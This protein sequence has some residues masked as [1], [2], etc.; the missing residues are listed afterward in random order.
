MA[1]KP[2]ALLL[3][4]LCVLFCALVQQTEAQ[5]FTDVTATW[6]VGDSGSGIGSAWGD[7]DADGDLDLY[8][9]FSGG[10]TN[11]LYTNTG[12]A[13][14]ASGQAAQTGSNDNGAVWGDYDGDGDLDLFTTDA[15]GSD[16]L[17]QNSGGSFS[18]VAATAGVQTGGDYSPGWVDYDRDGDLDLYIAVYGAANLLFQ[19]DGTGSFSD[20]ASTAGVASAGNTEG[21]AWG[22]YNN[23]G[24]PDLYIADNSAANVLYE[25]AGDGTF[26]D[27]TSTATVGAGSNA[28]GPAWGDY[29][30]DG[31]LDLHVTYNSG[32][33]DALYK[34]NGDGTF[35]D[36]ASGAGVNQANS[37]IASGWADFDFDGDLDVYVNVSGAANLLYSNN[38]NG[39]FTDV[40][41]TAS[42][43][44][45]GVGRGT[46]WGDVDSDGDLDLFINNNGSKNKLFQNSS[47]NGKSWLKVKLTGDGNNTSAIGALV[48]AWTGGNSQRLQVEGISSWNSQSSPERIFGFGNA[49]TVDS[50]IV[51]WPSG[52]VSASFTPAVSATLSL[53]EPALTVF[54]SAATTAGVNDASNSRSAAWADYDA[55][56][57]LDL[58]VGNQS[59]AN[60]LYKNSGSST[61][62]DDA[63]TAGVDDAGTAYGVAWADYDGDGLLDLALA[64]NAG[65][66]RL[67]SNAGD[68]TFTEDATAAGVDFNGGS[69]GL[70]WGDYDNDGWVDLYLSVNG[71]A[72]KLYSNA[73]DGTFTEIGAAAGVDDAGTGQAAMWGDYDG[74]GALDLALANNGGTTRLYNNNGNGTFTE[75]ASAAG[76]A[77]GSTVRGLSWADFI[78]DLYIPDFSGG[79]DALYENAGNGTFTDVA[80]GYGLKDDTAHR[81]VAWGDY[82]NDGRLDL[83]VTGTARNKLHLAR[84][85]GPFSEVTAAAGI[86]DHNDSHAAVFGDYDGDGDLDLFVANNGLNQFYSNGG[87]SNNWL[88]VELEGTSS[89]S[90]GIGALVIAEENGNKLYREIGGSSGYF[91]QSAQWAHFGF[92]TASG[93]IDKVTVVWTSGFSNVLTSIS[94]DQ[95]LLLTERSVVSQTPAAGTRNAARTSNVSATF[96][97]PVT[98][99]DLNNFIVHGSQSGELG[100]AYSGEGTDN[101]SF[102]PTNDFLPGEEI[103]VRFADGTSAGLLTVKGT[104]VKGY[105]YRL[106]AAAGTGPAEFTSA[107]SSPFSSST[108]GV[109]LGDVDGDG[110]LDLVAA[111][112]AKQNAVYLNDGTGAMVGGPNN[113]GTGSDN[114][115]S[116]DLGDLDGDGDLDI[117][118]GNINE[119]NTSHLND[120]SGGFASSANFGT[121]SDATRPVVLGDL[122]G[123][124]YMDV[125]VGNDGAQN[126]VYYND[127]AGALNSWTSNFGTGT[128]ATK[129]LEIG[130]VDQDGD[131]DLWLG[132]NSEANKI[133]LNGGWGSF[134]AGNTFG[135]GSDPSHWL[136][137]GDVDGD[138]DMDVVSANIGSQARPEINDGAGTFSAGTAFGTAATARGLKLGDVD[139]DGDLDAA[140]SYDSGTASSVFLNNA[141]GVFS[142]GTKTFAGSGSVTMQVALGDIDGDL[143]LDI[144]AGNNGTNSEVH[145]NSNAPVVNSISPTAAFAS[146]PSTG[147]VTATF[148]VAVTAGDAASFVVHSSMRGK[149]A[150]AYSGNNSTTLTFNPTNNFFPGETV[151]ST[152]VSTIQDGS[153]GSLSKGY[154]W[155]FT[156]QAAVGPGQFTSVFSNYGSSS[157]ADSKALAVGDID[158]DGDIDAVIAH[159]NGQQNTAYLNN[160]TGS[161]TASVQNYGTGADNSEAIAL[162]DM[163]GD[164]DVDVALGNTSQQNIAYLNNG[165]GS[166]SAGSTNFG[167]GSDATKAVALGDVDG[168][169]DLDLG[170]GNDGAQNAVYL[171]NGS[172][173]LSAGTTNFGTGSDA[174]FSLVFGDIDNDGD[175]DLLV[176]NNVQQ[177]VAYLNDGS[178]GLGTSQNFGTGS[179]K[180]TSIALGDIDGD[181]DLDVAVG[182]NTNTSSQNAAH[183]NNGSGVFS[184]SQNFGT[185]TDWTEAVALSDVDGD[186]DLDVI[187]ANYGGQ[188]AAYL[189]NGSGSFSAGTRNLG[190]ATGNT[191][192][193]V[194]GDV[195]GDGDIDIF[196]TVNNANDVLYFN[197]VAPTVSSISPTASF[198][199][200]PSTGNVTATFSIAVTAGDAASFVVH[201]SMRG[202]KA[203]AYSG[204]N[205]TTLTF[206]PTND[207]YPG[208]TVFST[209]VSTIND[210]SGNSLNKGYVWG[211]TVETAVGPGSFTSVFSNFGTGSDVTAGVDAGD[212]DGD[213]DLDIAQVNQGG[214]GLVQLNNGTGTFSGNFRY[215]GGATDPKRKV[216]LVDVDGDGD[217]DVATAHRPGQ[218]VAYL[219]DGS[220]NFTSSNNIGPGGDDTYSIH[221]ADLNGDGALDVAAGNHN[222]Q[223]TVHLNNGSGVLNGSSINFG[224]GSDATYVVRLADVDNDGDVDVAVGNNAQQDVLYFNDGSAGFGT[225]SNF[226]TG[227][228]AT[229]WI[230]LADVDGDGDTD[231]AVGS[232]GGQD[233]AYLNDGL[234]NFNAGTK[235]FGTGSDNTEYL[236]FGDGDGDGDVDIATGHWSQQDVVYVNDGSGNFS[237]GSNFGT[238]SDNTW[239][240]DFADIDGDGD[241]DLGSGV[242]GQNV[243][244]L[245]AIAPTVSSLSPTAS[246]ASAPSTG[247]VTATFSMAVTGGDAASFV[248]HSSMR[249]KKAGAYSGNNS[250]T[251]TFNPT[252]NFFPGETVFS[253]LTTTVQNTAGGK[254]AKG[255]VWGFRVQAAV[256]SAVFS[257]AASVDAA[258]VY[259]T[260]YTVLG[261]LDGDGDL[262]LVAGNMDQVNR[263]YLAN[264][265]GTFASG[266]DIDTPTNTNK[267]GALG[268]LD[269]DG[270]LDFVSGSSG[271]ANRVYLSNGN[272]TFATGND[273][274][275]PANAT[276]SV[277]LGDLDGD[278]DLDLVTGNQN[279]VNRVYLSN[280]NGTFATGNDVDTPTD[281]TIFTAL[282]DLDGDGDLDLVVAN[283][284]TNKLHLGNGDGT[285]SASSNVDTPTDNTRKIDLGDL[286]SDGDLDL[287]TVNSGAVNR[288]YLSNGNGTFAA[289]SQIDASVNTT[290]GLALGDVDGDGDLDLVAGNNGEANRAYLSN[291]NGTFASGSDVDAATNASWSI[292]LGDLDGDGDLDMIEG[293]QDLANRIQLNGGTSV[294][295]VSSTSPA[296]AFSNAPSSGNVT[297]TFSAAVTGGD[298]ASFRV[299]GSMSGKVS[300]AYSGNNSTTLT[301]NPTNNFFAGETVFST[302]V[303][304]IRNSSNGSLSSGYAWSFTAEST[305]APGNFSAVFS[306][307]VSANVQGKALALGDVD[308]DGDL[309]LALGKINEQSVL[310]DNDGSGSFT[311]ATQNIGGASDHTN[312]MS[313]GDVDG[314]GD[315][316]LALGN[317]NGFG[318]DEVYFNDGSGGFSLNGTVGPSANDTWAVELADMDGD[319]FLDVVMGNH[320]QQN[321]V[322]LNDKTGN[323]AASGLNFGNSDEATFHLGIGDIDNDGDLDAVMG[324]TDLSS[325]A[326]LQ[327]KAFFNDGTGSLG[328]SSNFGTGSDNSRG[329]A[330]GD[331]DGDGDLDVAVGNVS[332]EQNAVYLNNG[333][334]TFSAGTRNFGSADATHGVAF[335][336][337]DGDGDLDIAAANAAQQNKVFLNDGAGNFGSTVDYGGASDNSRSVAMGDVDGDGD[338]DLLGGNQSATS[339]V[340][341]NATASS[342]PTVSSTSPTASFASAPSTGNVTATFS[343]AVT[344]GDAASFVVHSSMRG[345]KAGAFSGNNSTTLTFNPT[346]N[347]FPGETVFS[348]L[349]TTV[350]NSSGTKLAKG[351]VWGFTVEAAVGP[352]VFNNSTS[353][354]DTPTN[355]TRSVSLGDVDGDGD[356]DLLAGN[357]AQVNRVYLSNG[358]GSFASGSDVDTPTNGT[359][360]VTL[361]DLDG[362]GDLDL[363]T[364]NNA[365]VNRVYL[366]NGNGTFASG[367]DVDAPTNNTHSMSL[368]DLDGDG[369]LDLVTG[370][371]AQV[372][373]VYLSNGNGTFAS[374]GDVDTPTNNTL[375][376]SLGDL[377][378]DGDLDLVAGNGQAGQ[379]NRVY[380][381]NGNGTFASGSDVDTPTNDTENVSLGDL[382]GDGDLD[383]V[384]GNYGQVNRLYLGNG[385]GTFA[386]GSDVDTPTNNTRSAL[387][388]DVDGDGDLD[389]ITGND[390]ANR[391]YL[392]NGNGTFA[393]GSDVDTPT[394]ATHSITLGDMDGDGDLDIVTGNEAQVNR[395]YL[396]A[397]A[398]TAPTVSSTSPTASF[399]S[400]PS[401]GNVTATFS[402]AVTGGDA[403]SFRVFG[404][405]SGKVSGAYSGNNSTTLTFNP[406]NNF[407]PGE[408]V[409]STLVSTIRDGSGNSLSKGYSW[410]FVAAANSGPTNFTAVFSSVSSAGMPAWSAVLGDVDADGDLDAGLSSLGGQNVVELN[411]GQGNFTA[412]NRTFGTGTD[413][414][415]MMALADIDGDGDLD[416]A[417]GNKS[418]EQNAAYLNDGS[419]N[420]NAGTRNFGTGSDETWV[421]V[422]GDVDSDGDVD[423]AVGNYGTQNVVYFNDGAGNFSAGSSNFGSGSEQTQ[424]MLFGDID[425]DGDLDLAV[426]NYAQQNV[427]YKN[428]GNGSF[429]AG[430]VNFG[431]ASDNTQGLA[432]GDIDGDGDLDVAAGNYLQQNAAYLNDGAGN[433]TAGTKNFGTGS[434]ATISGVDFA[435]VDVDSDLDVVV[436]NAGGQNVIYLNDASGNFSAGTR[437]FGTG[438]DN[439]VSVAVGDVDGDGDLDLLAGVSAGASSVHF[440]AAAPFEEVVSTVGV[441]GTGNEMGAAVGDFDGDGDQDIFV[442]AS[443][444]ANLLY[445]NNGSGSFTEV[446]SAKGV[447]DAGDDRG[448]SFGDYDADGDLDL[449]VTRVGAGNFLYKNNGSGSFTDDAAT[450]GVVDGTTNGQG[451]SWIDYDLDGDL[452]L[453]LANTSATASRLFQNNGA[454]VFTDV[455][456]SVGVANAG[457][458]QQGAWADYDADGDPDL[459][460]TDGASGGANSLYRNDSGGSSFQDV[461]ATAGVNNTGISG[462]VVWVDYDNDGDFDIFTVVQSAA[463]KLYRNDGSG[464]FVDVASTVGVDDTGGGYSTSVGDFDND[465]DE[466]FVVSRVTSATNLFYINSGT[467]TFT[468]NAANMGVTGSGAGRG[469][470][471]GDFD[472]DGDLDLFVSMYGGANQY[473]RNKGNN[474][475]WLHVKLAGNGSTTNKN[476]I[477]VEVK[478]EVGSTVQR[479]VVDGGSGGYSQP[480]LPV[481]FGLGGA[482]TVDK[483]I[484]TWAD[485]STTVQTNVS[486]N[487]TLTINE[488][489]GPQVSSV[490]PTAAF[491]SAPSTGN[492]TATFS[493]AVTAADAAS[494]VVHSSMRGKRAGAYSGNNS[495]T[496]TFN[497][498]NNFFPGETVF[499]TLTTTVQNSSG[500]RLSKG[501]VWSFNVGA[502]VAPTAFNN[503]THDVATATNT[504][505]TVSLGDLDGDGDLDLLAGNNGEANLVYLGNLDGTFSSGSSVSTASNATFSM[506]L[507]DLDGDGDLDLLEGNDNQTNQLY[508]GN[509]NGTFAGGSNVDATSNKTYA[510]VLGDLDG[511][512]D[513]DLVAGNY[514]SQ[515]NRVYLS[516]GNGT[517]ATGNDVDATT[518][519][520]TSVDVGDLDGDGDLDLLVGDYNQVNS[521]YLGNGDGTFASGNQVDG[522]VF[523]TWSIDLG[524]LD[525][526]GDLDLV[527]GGA[528]T[529]VNRVYLSN[530]NGTFANGNNVDSPTNSTRLI[531]L[532]DVDGDGD[533]DLVAANEGQANR[534]YLSNGNGTFVAGSDLATPT[535][536]TWAV[537]LGDL[538]GDGDLDLVAGNIGQVN[539]VYLNAEAVLAETQ[540]ASGPGG[541]HVA[542][543]SAT[544]Q[545][546][547]IGV[548]GDGSTSVSSL[549][550]TLSDLSTAT[551]MVAA[552]LSA[553]C[554]YSSTDAV[555]DQG[556]A[557]LV[558][559]TAVNIGSATTLSFTADTVPNA[560]QRYY[561]AVAKIAAS[562]T[563]GHAFRTSFAAGGLQTSAGTIGTAVAASDNDRVTVGIVAS[564]LV[565]TTQPSGSTSGSALTTQPVLQAQDANGN[566][567]SD[568]SGT[569][570]LTTTAAGTLSNATATLSAGV[571]TFSGLSYAAT[572]DGESVALTAASSGLSSAT[573]T[574][575]VADVIATKLVFTT[576]PAGA[577]HA[578]ALTTQ[579]VVQAQDASG[580]LDTGMSGTVTLAAS[581]GALSN[582]TA[583]MSAGVATFSGL[584][585]SGISSAVTLTAAFSSSGVSAA[586][587]NGLAVVIAPLS[588]GFSNQSVVYDGQ[589]KVIGISSTP[590]GVSYSVTYDGSATAPTN[591]GTYTVVATATDGNYTGTATTQFTITGPAAPTTTLSASLTT[592]PIPLTVQFA[593]VSTGDYS[594]STL[595]TG[596][597]DALGGFTSGSVT[598]TEPGTYTAELTVSGPG[599]S[600]KSSQTIVVLGP[601]TIAAI[602]AGTAKEDEVLTL[603]L[604]GKD[605]GSGT[606]SVSGL[607]AA[608]I[609]SH[610]IGGD[611]LTFTPVKDKAGSTTVTVTRTASTGLSTLQAVILT[612]TPVDDPPKIVNL[613]STSSGP[614]DTAITVGGA[615]H[616]V[617]IDSD[618]SKFEWSASGYK[619]ELVAAAAGGNGGVVF[620]PLKDKFGQTTAKLTLKD[621][622]TG[623]EVAQDVTLTWMPVNDPP[624]PPAIAKPLDKAIDI[625]LATVLSWSALDV[626]M[627]P[628]KFDVFLGVVGQPQVKVADKQT[629]TTYSAVGLEPGTDYTWRIVARDPSEL[630]AETTASFKTEADKTPPNISKLSATA[631]NDGMRIVWETDEKAE[632]ILNY[633]S[634]PTDPALVPEVGEI[635]N[636]TAA[637][638]KM[639]E[640]ALAQLQPATWYDFSV[641]VRDRFNNE[642]PATTSRFRTLAAPDIIAPVITPG[643]IQVNGITEEGG[644]VRW[645]TDE[646]SIGSVAYFRVNTPAAKLAQAVDGTES[647]EL[648]ELTLSRD[649]ALQLT[650]LRTASRYR[651]VITATD[652]SNNSSVAVEQHFTTAAKADLVAPHFT[653]GPGARPQLVT[654]EIE[655]KAD[656]VVLVEVR[657]D[658]DMTPAD[659]SVVFGGDPAESHQVTLNGLLPG[660]TYSYQVEV[661]DVGTNTTTS[662]ILTFET[663]AVADLTAA[664]AE[665]WQVVPS[666]ESALLDFGFDELVTARVLWWP[667]ADPTAVF[668]ADIGSAALQHKLTLG[669]LIAATDYAY[670]IVATDEG[671][672]IS[673]PIGGVF[674]TEAEP[675]ILNPVIVS[676]LIDAKTLEGTVLLVDVNELVTLQG[677]LTLTG[678][679]QDVTVTGAAVGDSKTIGSALKKNHS[680]AL[681]QLVPGGDYRVD[682]VVTDPYTNASSGLL[683]FK[684]PLR[685]DTEAPKLKQLPSILSVSD[686][687]VRLGVGYNENVQLKVRYFPTADATTAETRNFTKRQPQHEVELN[688]LQSG[689]DYTAEL[690]ARDA[691]KLVNTQSISFTT[692]LEPDIISPVFTQL[693]YVEDAQLTSVRLKFEADEPVVAQLTLTPVDTA[694]GTIIQEFSANAIEKS[695]A[696]SLEVSGLSPGVR[697]QYNLTIKDAKLNET[698]VQDVVST[699]NE[700]VLPRIVE[701][702]TK[703]KIADDRAWI[704]LK[705][706]IPTRVEVDYALESSP[707]NIQSEKPKGRGK[708][709]V[710]QLTNL[711]P[712]TSYIYTTRAVDDKSKSAS[713]PVSGT[714]RTAKGPDL[715]PPQIQGPP[716]VTAIF[717]SRA[718]IVWQ[719]DEPSDTKV[720]GTGPEGVKVSATNPAQTLVHEI[721]LTN[722]QPASTYTYRVSSTDLATNT[723]TSAN[724]SFTT[725]AVPDILPPVF[726]QNPIFRS[727][728]HNNVVIAYTANEPSTSTVEVGTT[729]NYELPKSTIGTA[730][731]DH[732]IQ[733]NGLAAGTE[734]HFRVGIS[735]ALGNGPTF[736]PNFVVT[737]DAAPD[738][739]APVI[740][741]GPLAVT[742]TESKAIIEW[743]T[744]EPADRHVRFWKKDSPNEGGEVEQGERVLAHQVVLNNLEPGTV[745]EYAASSTDKEANGPTTS[746]VNEFRTKDSPQLPAITSGPF[747]E[748]DESSATITWTTNVPS[749]SIVDLGADTQYGAHQE[750]KDLVLD[751][752]VVFENLD[753]AVTYHYKVTSIDLSNNTV[754]TDK[755]GGQSYS[756]D[757][758]VRTLGQ[759][760]GQPPKLIA[761]PVA[762]W[763]NTTV[764]ISWETDE[765][766]TSRIEWLNLRTGATG[767]VDDNQRV[768]QHNSTLTGLKPRTLYA[769]AVVSEDA[770]GNK[771]TWQPSAAAKAAAKM[772]Y[773]RGLRNLASGKVAQPP[774]GAGTFVTDSFPDTRLPV[775]TAGP[776]VR[777]K[778][779]ESVTIEWQTDELADSFVRFGQQENTLQE[780]VGAG[781]DVQ[782]HS[783][784]LTNLTPS[785]SYFFKVESTDPSGNG[786]T[787]SGIAVATTAA[788]IDLSPPRYVREPKVVATTDRQ[789]TLEWLG[790]EAA[791]ATIEYRSQNSEVLVRQVRER[792]TE[793][794][795]TLTNLTP[796][797][798][799]QALILLRDAN[800]NQTEQPFELRFTTDGEPDLVPPR[801]LTEPRIKV[802]G[803]RSVIIVWETDELSDSFVDFDTSPYLGQVVGN[804]T[805]TTQHEIRLTNLEPDSTYF[806]RAGSTDRAKNGPIESPVSS[807]TTLSQPDTEPPAVPSAVQA[808][809]GPEAV[810]L[811][812]DAV[813]ASDLGGYTVYREDL[814]RRFV[815]VATGLTQASYLDVGLTNR[816]TYRYRVSASD[817]QTPA[818]ES[819]SSTIITARPSA[820]ALGE[821]PQIVGL[822]QGAEAGKPVVLIGNAVPLDVAA[823]LSYT[824]QVSTQEDFSTM[825]DR[826]G[827]I[828]E[829]PSGTTRWRLTRALDPQASYWFRTRIFD[830]RFEGPWSTPQLLRPADA[831]TATNSED[832][833]GDGTVGFRDFF[834]MS[835][836]FGST[837]AVLD[838]DQGGSVDGEDFDRFKERFGEVMPAKRLETQRIAVAEGSRVEVEAEAISANRVVVRLKL[839]GVKDLSGY[840]FSL[841][842]DPPILRYMGRVD[843]ALFGGRGA[844]LELAHEGD[845]LAIGEHLRGRQ[846]ALDLSE[847]WEIALLFEMKGAPRNVE[848]RVEE[849]YLGTG[850]G[851]MLRVEQEGSAR[852]VPQVYALYANYP[853]PFNPSTSIPL[854]IPQWADG[855]RRE[856]VSLT[857]FN[858]LGQV[859]RTWDLSGWSPG[860]HSLNWDG[861]D[862]QGHAVASGV[863][864]MRLRAGEFVQVR[865]AL[866]LR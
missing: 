446:A 267:S 590:S 166:F 424:E 768:F 561:I 819:A 696:H 824:V 13:F 180:T 68:G 829:S 523:A 15:A 569:V 150:G 859:V 532:G 736:F 30:N 483:L 618:M 34:N 797:T 19:N 567:D 848:L 593:S 635:T 671:G 4:S 822:E 639:F 197:A 448:A 716:S 93:N 558:A 419:G 49:T 350:Q 324:N 254:L 531:K 568:F 564:K 552:D 255:H 626:D 390:T 817:A 632:F 57:D 857:L 65:T 614:E 359:H 29:N 530:G 309:D 411:D 651:L 773:D 437:N 333:S 645:S 583:T 764:V 144:V 423:V 542:A 831:L 127:G 393:S 676:A 472:S 142:A 862:G 503:V 221:F 468:E 237:A 521:V 837:D 787:E 550:L 769:I 743:S 511:D 200:A 394:N 621:P 252:N 494:F 302:L 553:L 397:L 732:E 263:V 98:A 364:G 117:V 742:T 441:N 546:F 790:D 825:V 770:A 762:K 305:V 48:E 443:N 847:G 722:L 315:L 358:N 316:D 805:Y 751:H 58:Y 562:A 157:G 292:S 575:F 465:G 781:Q 297:A 658:T 151:F 717:D 365:Q 700:I 131:L 120:G 624:A 734:Y 232:Y 253:T 758:T 512:G 164:G 152:L 6:G 268:D 92:G 815:A 674:T 723:T 8:V 665:G 728:S 328:T 311:A 368:G 609:A 222:A 661:V 173:S 206:N 840:G 191:S 809:A 782:Q 386:S 389:F 351:Y 691:A 484:V 100:G 379:V 141:S 429:T 855:R 99:V 861:R 199:S 340:Y 52:Q 318:N 748:A 610:T 499:S 795:V 123:D 497:P 655:L 342:A 303:S 376:V 261:D 63:A 718:K 35:T 761:E 204:N 71:A 675:D 129:G 105:I 522:S 349:T 599:G 587:S 304:T 649:H 334:G 28:I 112:A 335:G 789:A 161:L 470:V 582:A 774:G 148:S 476:G 416:V 498:T 608:Q 584:A 188:D 382:D 198:A 243:V 693:P 495:T 196:T 747:A 801:F 434:D 771:M 225:S 565:F 672:N 66:N 435:D 685:P 469:T 620:T 524:D 96:S 714:F 233:A 234:G 507:G 140:L 159:R 10:A 248:V 369:D 755:D 308:G 354:V 571:A 460:L 576:Q 779:T 336:D 841:A 240:V 226:G 536:N 485:G 83:F 420:F 231:V 371:H 589:A 391:L 471:F 89:N 488:V 136:A 502:A 520:T 179:D 741:T 224:T 154:V 158:G 650:G 294:P 75:S 352:A 708:A 559:Q 2:I 156:V 187:A 572:A 457:D 800:S 278:G 832:F 619:P 738:I 721:E 32:T 76:I 433:F 399:A 765:A 729:T 501:Y 27:V 238:G 816:R 181:G 218:N 215:F 220:G 709:H 330:L 681:T 720:A 788:G 272:G 227:S 402:A 719:T 403:A 325:S 458:S 594:S 372:N 264:G 87:N 636:G 36:D 535:N 623:L 727:V 113:F 41:A 518:N 279:Q 118:A 207:F 544:Q 686:L 331:V 634:V 834:I 454:G 733:I 82:D 133:Y 7:Y 659:G 505:Q 97:A 339:Y 356:L 702:P 101:P 703:Q 25:N 447:A 373:R 807:F 51:R 744:D 259:A 122:D 17:W 486:T 276:N 628:L 415:Q 678:L 444:T 280:G 20:V 137:V 660:T 625:P 563:D 183:L 545:I 586:T 216:E 385:N 701:G 804:P 706:N 785:T 300:G 174:T 543:A 574:A 387:L 301:F 377:D 262:D 656:E 213:G 556:D 282:G 291:G 527:E 115:M 23:D 633:T 384:T 40:A 43:N 456:G 217:L 792:L 367:N 176:G 44:D 170:A 193:V 707:T 592:G 45:A 244:Y 421:A 242:T 203:G 811:E 428:D 866:L 346:N 606:W 784:T 241:L 793:Q 830:G 852:I 616:A 478:A 735:D 603:N 566:V 663:R 22:D 344:G 598:Y 652:A 381:G 286:D 55:D 298:A 666:A 341:F 860:F 172:G 39:T 752:K 808:T 124:G 274:D 588:F 360:S 5:S 116:V 250:T 519:N 775:I 517:F 64:N 648:K 104:P 577:I 500:N 146:A 404:S 392:S 62:T 430:S 452:D 126:V 662:E 812:W 383:L 670:E 479:R 155:G 643:S 290:Q 366:G 163:D 533:L 622:V 704:K 46:S 783:I 843:S 320:E 422:F 396:N 130:D 310:L 67:Y 332:N 864:L 842:A 477:G 712:D 307:F 348:T 405:M 604:T 595:T 132:N 731:K 26:T 573:A 186:S 80:Q 111:N 851:R 189:N 185:G 697:Y 70:A 510:T 74:D 473:Y 14:T 329:V 50:V 750:Q 641:R 3:A 427:A 178:G 139:G 160:G 835:N 401:T 192:F 580:I 209:L 295:T 466:D 794:Q 753:P 684:A 363:L 61:F 607:D 60:K 38:G 135:T 611:I 374:G 78:L 537:D 780:V 739:V 754:T 194:A 513:L 110:D 493:A 109:D 1:A 59:A 515:V 323:F 644:W 107:F 33:A 260:R 745:Y 525:G 425:N 167:S 746:A 370:N 235:N 687:S 516:N 756:E 313:F 37:A 283:N 269:G 42:V 288:V 802:L 759:A 690:T 725:L 229:H 345:K 826:G 439:T 202:K 147:N 299:F 168:D 602:G 54:S 630:S 597:G 438:S 668:F 730:A 275:T 355:S 440:N 337:V 548:T 827:N 642:S 338:I 461:S 223:N 53:S 145:F 627:D 749:N 246:F 514:S 803:D 347:F 638:A 361:G 629:A 413:N 506:S 679:P 813:G 177:N 554:V 426:G 490:S 596:K 103:E 694:P 863:Y 570:T 560:T 265:N 578:T 631:V 828:I 482:S 81:G 436:G 211:F 541:A 169:G 467:G 547:H 449:Y 47:A 760:D 844:S 343:A 557:L 772:A 791:S 321:T 806:F 85:N 455:A 245:N 165:S 90:Y 219:N 91:S 408:T 296:A 740:L 724:Y 407:F 266:S 273:V 682:Y 73:G 820:D 95:N 114:T 16:F 646:L 395:V 9:V 247:N 284:T 153:G 581:A 821:L 249:G 319:G 640:V 201:G 555:F 487:Q 692:L 125:A 322:Y 128:D 378:M 210:G 450:A 481:E 88:T 601:P 853:N 818:N 673:A 108:H 713:L 102:N 715:I 776:R 508:L 287:I 317:R 312:V 375:S 845:V 799:Y 409:F 810:L 540:A 106:T 72:N 664:T 12:S 77:A 475:K 591:P 796:N 94:T 306:S 839:D 534:L 647:G 474:N 491:A 184:G 539:R 496:L 79:F 549:T 509:G 327:N 688:G 406:T 289:G 526:D 230:D 463:D 138:G 492:V 314:D 489:V 777:E 637:P 239:V 257:S 353:D 417:A 418:A 258:S 856:A 833:D 850:R 705:T 778:S 669:N 617:D 613:S 763:T 205:S 431:G 212:V 182:N 480:S 271:Q 11:I 357:N 228:D 667:L 459:Y 600:S 529:Q 689:T 445:Q 171:N 823:E 134:T 208:E 677:T 251:L 143:D 190:S 814:R 414:T 285:F 726:T 86:V 846:S 612:W 737:T 162:G 538:D 412:G 21:T 786:A 605:T 462:G 69:T 277:S 400:A 836:G 854:A 653:E 451:A 236:S 84:S 464:S 766:S 579:P 442:A 695:T 504:T 121:G 410:S 380:L 119:Q 175:L 281:P 528:F 453:Y 757:L 654:A 388:G 699:I 326:S 767:F 711:L 838:L 798:E 24:W 149:K 680:V 657:Y 256:G 432:L 31:W 865:K 585:M 293:N 195:D 551:G 710:V 362:D 615:A 858:A 18:D 398:S 56:G 214:Q 698:S 270:D 849:G 683:T